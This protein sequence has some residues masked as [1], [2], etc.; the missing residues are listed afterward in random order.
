MF[1]W[2]EQQPAI[3]YKQSRLFLLTLPIALVVAVGSVLAARY[4]RHWPFISALI[5]I[6]IFLPQFVV[7]WILMVKTR[8]LRRI[9]RESGG[10]VCTHCGHNL[11][12]LAD[13]GV[14]PE[15]GEAFDTHVD[16]TRWAGAAG[17]TRD[18]WD[19]PSV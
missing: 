2:S 12:G 17:F 8:K 16:R 10:R 1:W 19:R 5:P 9:W 3:L 15:C 11:A 4:L 6:G 14:C 7:M 13:L 18:Q